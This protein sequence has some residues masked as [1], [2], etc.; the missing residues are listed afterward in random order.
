MDEYRVHVKIDMDEASDL[1]GKEGYGANIRFT[2]YQGEDKLVIPS[3][4]V[5][6]ADDQDYVFVIKNGRAQKQPVEIEYKTTAQAVVKEGLS[7]GQ[8]V[9]DHV[10]SEEI[11]EG[12]KVYAD[13]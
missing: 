1:E 7:E 5:F 4:A 6:R 13:S 3:S 11:Y 12:A 8:K 10:D 2:L 9:I